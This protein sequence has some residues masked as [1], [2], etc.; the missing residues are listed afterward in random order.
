MKI[1]LITFFFSFSLYSGY[2]FDF[3]G[4]GSWWKQK[5]NKT[6]VK[7]ENNA[8]IMDLVNGF[9]LSVERTRDGHGFALWLVG[10]KM[11]TK[12]SANQLLHWTGHSRFPALFFLTAPVKLLHCSWLLWLFSFFC[13]TSNRNMPLY[14]ST[15]W[16]GVL[17]K[18]SLRWSSLNTFFPTH[19]LTPKK[20]T[21]RKRRTYDVHDN[22]VHWSFHL[23]NQLPKS[24]FFCWKMFSSLPQKKK[25]KFTTNANFL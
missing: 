6:S 14:S 12:L 4:G 8:G 20:E 17:F 9:Q 19:N 23:L 21:F 10:K 11:L 18:C 13:A 24:T 15:N 3:G 22:N 1:F 25:K 2:D 16:H 7:R 5:E